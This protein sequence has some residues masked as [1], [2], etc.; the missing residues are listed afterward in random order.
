[1]TEMPFAP[2]S[3]MADSTAIGMESFSA[4]EKSTMSMASALVGLRVISQVSAVAPRLYGTSL[5]ARWYACDS[6][7]L[8]SFS[9]S[10]IM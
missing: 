10:S 8:L 6:V 7:S 4:Q 5:S 1:M 3:R 2:L 9:E